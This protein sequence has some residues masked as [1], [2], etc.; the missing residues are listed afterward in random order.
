[1]PKNTK[2]IGL[3]IYE[4]TNY[5]LF[6]F[7]PSNRPIEEHHVK[8]VMAEI[9]ANNFL[10]EN[11]VKVNK[12]HE[13]IE[14]QHTFEACVRLEIPVY[15]MY[16]KMDKTHIGRFNSSRKQWSMENVLH[17]YCVEGLQDYKILA[18]FRSRHPYPLSTLIILLSGEHTKKILSEYRRGEFRVGQSLD[19]VE[20][21]LDN[22]KQFKEYNDKI[23]RH[24]TFILG[25]IDVLTHPDFDHNVFIHKI[26]LVPARFVKQETRK[27]YFR[28][29]EDI[30][31][32]RN[33]N[34]IRLF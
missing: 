33:P 5:G 9:Q 10:A 28:M 27:D 8:Y 12:S 21:L 23:Y 19:S 1:M 3:S 22:I 32:Y 4:T 26:T 17:H 14:G 29:I 6:K 16:T 15:F 20:K 24:R 2:K 30:Y 7:I 11:P 31:N 13:I 25:Y 18:G 34:P